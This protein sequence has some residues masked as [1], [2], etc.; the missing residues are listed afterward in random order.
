MENILKGI[1]KPNKWIR[2]LKIMGLVAA[3]IGPLVGAVIGVLSYLNDRKKTESGYEL[4]SQGINKNSEEIRS[5]RE[6]IN[7]LY[8]ALI[9]SKKKFKYP[10]PP[11]RRFKKWHELE[12]K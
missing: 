7:F 6:Q 3:I 8:Q 1:K 11:V 4:H 12:G 5:N 10:L 9:N 2:R